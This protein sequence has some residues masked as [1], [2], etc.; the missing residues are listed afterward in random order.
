MQTF[1]RLASSSLRRPV[2]ST[3]RRSMSMHKALADMGETNAIVAGCVAAGAIAGVFTA[4]T[5]MSGSKQTLNGFTSI[6]DGQPYTTDPVYVSA[7]VAYRKFQNMDPIT[8]FKKSGR[9]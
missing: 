1:A 6:S 9:V 3:G 5:R 2:V 7:N 8:E 4:V